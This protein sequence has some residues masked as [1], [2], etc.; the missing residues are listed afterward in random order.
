MNPFDKCD[1]L[2]ALIGSDPVSRKDC[3]YEATFDEFIFAIGGKRINQIVKIPA[4]SFNA[5][6]LVQIDDIEAIIELKQIHEQTASLMQVATLLHNRNQ[7]SSG[8]TR[9]SATQSALAPTNMTAR[10][11]YRLYA[12]WGRI[13]DEKLKIANRQ[14][15]AVNRLIPSEYHRIG[16]VV[17]LN[18]GNYQFTT[19]RMSNIAGVFLHKQ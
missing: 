8:L 19:S 7:I 2:K 1:Q 10:D 9:I 18:T 3:D 5:D 14:I 16:G 17:F 15:R 4:A 13:F 6:Y 11:R 12:H